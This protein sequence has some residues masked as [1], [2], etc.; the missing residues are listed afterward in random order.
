MYLLP[1]KASELAKPKHLFARLMAGWRYRWQGWVAPAGKPLSNSI[2]QGIAGDDRQFK[3]MSF[4]FSLVALS[5]RVACADGALTR[6]KYIAFRESFPLKG[7]ICSKIRSLFTLACTDRTPLMHYITHIKYS[8]PKHTELYVSVVDHLFRIA[9]ADGLISREEEQVLADVAHGLDIPAASYARLRAKYEQPS[10]AHR[11]LGLPSRVKPRELKKRYHELMRNYHPD[12]FSGIEL[13][14]EL[15]SLLELKASEI[16]EAY[17]V[18]R[19]KA[20]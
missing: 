5:A 4:T 3:H 20:A 7:G 6:E 11:V 16:N 10:P 8:H 14:P 1:K 17:R 2:L 15:Q 9:S 12:R 19:K 13:S 18:L